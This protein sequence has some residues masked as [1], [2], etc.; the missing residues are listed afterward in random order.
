MSEKWIIGKPGG[1]AGPFY[2]IINQAGRIIALQVPDK[3]TAEE[4][5]KTKARLEAAE[6]EYQEGKRVLVEQ[7]MALQDAVRALWPIAAAGLAYAEHRKY[8]EFNKLEELRTKGIPENT[9]D[10]IIEVNK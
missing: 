2:S 7:I 9:L 3:M 8:S 10:L 6:R 4:I 5:V 1:P